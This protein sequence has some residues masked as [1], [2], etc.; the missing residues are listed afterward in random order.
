MRLHRLELDA[1]GPFAG[2]EEVDF[3]ALS[4]SGLF[5]LS[6]PTGAGKTSVLDAV[7]FALFGEVPG[8]RG[9]A[10]RLASDHRDPATR[11]RVALEAT[12]GGRRVRVTRVPAAD[13]R[14]E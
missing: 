5:L 6:G 13:R 10:G 3:D 9:D 14:L 12:V 2:H 11:P 4:D 8:P 1:F 7:C